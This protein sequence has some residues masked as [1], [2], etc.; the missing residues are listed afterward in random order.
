[1]VHRVLGTVSFVCCAL[2]IASFGFFAVDQ[3]SGASEVQANETAGT[4]IPAAKPNPDRKQP[5]KF[6][7]AA[8]RRLTTPFNSLVSSR[9]EWAN[10]LVVLV[11]GLT[12]YGV[13]LGYLRRYTAGLPL[14][15]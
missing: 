7:D 9:S 8:S 5:R 10:H 12:L 2:I 13:G 1:M 11:C 14:R 6:I 15:A 3:M 4:P